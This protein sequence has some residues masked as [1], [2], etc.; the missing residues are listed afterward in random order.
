MKITLDNIDAVNFAGLVL[1]FQTSATA[2]LAGK[3]H[4]FTCPMASA[5]RR[6]RQLIA[7]NVADAVRDLL[8][9]KW[10]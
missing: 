4:A 6:G 9:R 3:L 8:E 2:R 1:A 5:R 7:N 10:V